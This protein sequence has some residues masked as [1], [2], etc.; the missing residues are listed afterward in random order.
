MQRVQPCGGQV[1]FAVVC[2]ARM[3]MLGQSRGRAAC[4]ACLG[5]LLRIPNSDSARRRGQPILQEERW[6][7]VCCKI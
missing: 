1:S 3:C 2:A 5:R 6:E 4:R 7:A